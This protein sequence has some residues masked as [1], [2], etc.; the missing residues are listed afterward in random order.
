[1]GF[2]ESYMKQKDKEEKNI[3]RVSYL[4]DY[5][6][7]KLFEK[8]IRIFEWNGLPFPQNELECRL[9]MYG[10]CGIV[11]DDNLGLMVANGS[12]SQPTQYSDIF[13]KFTYSAVGAKGGTFKINSDKC[14]VAKNDSLMTT[15]I[16][17][18]NIYASLLAHADITLK[19]SLVN[20]RSNST[21]VTDDDNTAENIS[22]WYNKLYDG[23]M[24][25]IV[26]ENAVTKQI[27]DNGVNALQLN[28]SGSITPLQA[29]EV[30]N[31]ILRSF[32][33][34]IGIRSSKE[35][36]GNMTQEEVNDNTTLLLFNINDMLKYRL[37]TCD[38]MNKFLGIKASVKLNETYKL[39]SEEG[40]IDDDI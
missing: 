35:K 37:Q 39:Y 18:I 26:D 31:E 20:M 28:S 33:S 8:C 21:F 9:M 27:G 23:E 11:K 6:R 36:R 7:N 19:S 30:R 10:Y 14:V 17:G 15:M 2:I 5:W 12:M 32:Y 1:M 24:G 34:E 16:S 13:K 3:V 22:V 29:I 25:A 4:F 40:S 38:D